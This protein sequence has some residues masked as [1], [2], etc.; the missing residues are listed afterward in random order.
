MMHSPP[1][2]SFPSA[3]GPSVISVA[4]SF[5][6]TIVAVLGACSP[7]ANTQAPASWSSWWKTPTFRMIPSSTSGAGGSPSV[8]VTTLSR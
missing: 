2:Y 8:G 3:Y 5:G 7:P 4:P 1:R 6:R